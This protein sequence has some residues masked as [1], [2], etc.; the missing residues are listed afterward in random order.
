[1]RRLFYSSLVLC[2]LAVVISGQ[3]VSQAPPLDPFSIQQGSSF[4]ASTDRRV[5][6]PDRIERY[7]PA[8]TRITNDFAEALELIKRNHVDAPVI[9]TMALTKSSI[10]SMLGELDPHSN[11]YDPTEFGV[12][13]GDQESEYSGTGSSIS[14]FIENGKIETYVVAVQPDSSSGRAHLR[15]GDR[16]VSVDGVSVRG[17]T[18]DSVRDRVRGPRGTVV[19]ILVERAATGRIET[20]DLLRDRVVQRTI[21]DSYILRDGVGYVNLSEGFSLTTSAEFD[22]VLDRLKRDGMR[23]LILDLRGNSGGVLDQAIRVAEKFLP[24]GM[25]IISQR[26]RAAEDNAIWRSVNPAPLDVPV[27]VLVD[28]RSASASEV[29]AGALQ[30]ND[31][32]LIVGRNTYGKSLVQKVLELPTGAGLTL[33]TGRYYTPSGRSIQRN[34]VSGRLY[35]YFSHH[36]PKVDGIEKRT[37]TNRPV[38]E[39]NGITPDE[40]IEGERFNLRR[41]AL[42]DPIF[43]FVRDVVKERALK[44]GVPLNLSDGEIEQRYIPRFRAYAAGKLWNIKSDAFDEE[45]TYIAR[46]LR[47]QLALALIGQHEANRVRNE[48]DQ[49][50]SKAIDA[51]PR[52][53]ALADSARRLMK[54]AD[55]K[56]PAGSHSRAGQGRN[57]RN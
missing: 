55:T 18:I 11:F 37:I 5:T 50:I 39:G 45:V 43:F 22:R 28:E 10:N 17:A 29:V 26:G 42:I 46:Q 33:T 7:S 27:V 35:D 15:Y 20:I 53:K 36:M 57:R 24:A 8:V 31:R 21:P 16:I 4:S 56:K 1:M 2:A 25:A 14:N 52:A 38:Y 40:S 48:F 23:S 44:P 41:A 34:Y 6:A 13:L 49:E 30:D 51:L 19:R 32:A 12:L 47:Y 3:T 9:D 54:P